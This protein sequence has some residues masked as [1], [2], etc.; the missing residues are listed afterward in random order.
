M[1]QF[2]Y[3]VNDAANLSFVVSQT[4]HVEAEVL[5][6]KYPAIT[7]AQDI[8]V[9]TSANPFATS[10]KFFASDMI[11]NA[12]LINGMADDMPLANVDLATYDNPVSM[13][14]I[15]YSFSLEQVGQAQMLGMNLDSAG[16][17]SARFAYEKFVDGAAFTGAGMGTGVTGLYNTAGITTVAATGVFSGLTAQ[18]ILT[19]V[20]TLLAG[21]WSSSLGVEMP[22]VLKFPLAVYAILVS[23]ER[24]S[25][26]DMT[27]LEFL[28]KANIYTA[29][30]GQPLIIQ[31]DHRLTT[32]AVAYAK[33]PNVL[34]LHIPMALRFLPPQPR[35]LSYVVPGMFRLAGLDI[36]RKGA[37]R[38]LD[39]VA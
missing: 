32:R 8:P 5:K 26:T 15:G 2:V 21:A 25:G 31:G 11:G 29:S 16:A 30:T 17:D 3:D 28:Q 19:D 33:D 24:A 1:T 9:D 36:R 18:Q 22:N 14:G 4:A 34:K 20:N 12:R 6:R 37:V 38:Y 13:A 39:G 7:Y 27:V 35:N 10:V 23:K